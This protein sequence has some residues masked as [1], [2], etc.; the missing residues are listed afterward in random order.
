M[1]GVGTF[2]EFCDTFTDIK[3][4]KIVFNSIDDVINLGI[5]SVDDLMKLGVNS[6][7]DLAKLKVSSID[8]LAKI[9]IKNADDLAKLGIDISHLK[10]LGIEPKIFEASYVKSIADL[11]NTDN[12][13]EGAL[14]HIL[15][16]EINKRGKAVGFHYEGFPTTKGSIIEDTKSIADDLGIYTGNVEVNGIV[17]TSNGGKS[18]FFPENWTAQEVVDAINEAFANKEF[19]QGTRNTF[20]GEL[21]NG[22]QIEMYIDNTTNKIISAFPVQ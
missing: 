6:V 13:R 11:K 10:N 4:G 5:N 14:E 7:D 17:K 15:E 12:F 20:I 22:M 8:D 19:V 21:S 16:G 18:T 2:S 1:N 9:G 3:N